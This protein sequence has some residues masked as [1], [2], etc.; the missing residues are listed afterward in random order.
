MSIFVKSANAVEEDKAGR[1]LLESAVYDAKIVCAY[2]QPSSNPASKSQKLIVQLDVNGTTITDEETVLNV[3]GTNTWK[4]DPTKLLSGFL[5]MNAFC[6]VASGVELADIPFEEKD[7][8]IN[9]FQGEQLVKRQVAVSLI[10]KKIKV[11]LFKATVNR[12]QNQGGNWVWTT[13]TKDTNMVDKYFSED[14]RTHSEMVKGTAAEFIH[15]WKSK[16]LG[17]HVQ[18]L[19]KEPTVPWIEPT[20]TGTPANAAPTAPTTSIFAQM[21]Q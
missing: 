14:G 11:G 21:K 1:Q 3:N 9:S 5:K 4:N 20:T 15:T 12:K 19:T 8:K 2:L 6:Y 16:Y 7:I 17:K 18:R 10:G 13:A